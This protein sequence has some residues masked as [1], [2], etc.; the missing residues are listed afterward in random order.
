MGGIY[1]QEEAKRR[2]CKRRQLWL[3][4]TTAGTLRDTCGS[5]ICISFASDVPLA[6]ARLTE[7]KLEGRFG[8]IRSSFGNSSMSISDYW[9][10]SLFQMKMEKAK[11]QPDQLAPMQ[12]VS[13]QQFFEC[14][15]RAWASVCKLMSM[16]S[17]M[18]IAEIE[19][20]YDRSGVQMDDEEEIAR[21]DPCPGRMSVGNGWA[22]LDIGHWFNKEIKYM[23]FNRLA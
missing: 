5:A 21:Q 12:S 23:F 20:L 16:C 17:D 8:R 15:K 22:W 7:R 1:A 14:G 9:R 3:D 10:A 2:G 4:P 11:Q 13:E 6:W 19:S 18:T